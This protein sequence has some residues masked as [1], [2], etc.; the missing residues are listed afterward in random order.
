MVN[1]AE[2]ILSKYIKVLVVPELGEC[3][4]YTGTRDSQGYGVIKRQNKIYKV[5]RLSVD[6]YVGLDH[7]MQ[8][9]HKCDNPPCINPQHL[10]QGTNADNV[11]DKVMRNR[12]PDFNG[13]KNPN[14]KLTNLDVIAIRKLHNSGM[15]QKDIATQYHVHRKTIEAIVHHKGRY[16]TI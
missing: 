16:G 6:Y 4:E 5:H 14:L 10:Y 9:L 7:D 2:Q 12:I 13:E 15:M 1:D 3:W 8:A 11:R